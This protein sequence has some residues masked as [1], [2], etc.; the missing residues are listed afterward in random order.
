MRPYFRL[1]LRP[2][3][4]TS[5]IILAL[6]EIVFLSEQFTGL[7]DRVLKTGGS[8]LDLLRLLLWEVPGILDLALPVALLVGVQ[9]AV[10]RARTQGE[11]VVLTAAGAPVGGL[12]RGVLLVG[13]L[14]GLLSFAIAGI[15]APAASYAQRVALHALTVQHIRARISEPGESGS[16][17]RAQGVDFVA[18]GTDDA[19]PSL[20]VRR[21]P[22]AR[23][24]RFAFAGEWEV[25]GPDEDGDRGNF[26][27]GQV[28]AFGDLPRLD[29]EM[30][31]AQM[32]RMAAGSVDV[33]FD[34]DD[35]LPVLDRTPRENERPV[36]PALQALMA[37]E[38]LDEATNPE[39]IARIWARALLV[40]TAALLALMAVWGGSVRGVRAAALPLALLALVA[41]DL[42]TRAWL[43]GIAAGPSLWAASGV[44]TL[45]LLGLPLAA[46]W[47]AGEA[48]VRPGRG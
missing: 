22:D 17:F 40:P 36:V 19:S 37:G 6:V 12:V 35:I 32:N 43:V 46:L 38:V 2:I 25:T 27:L 18:T 45:V 31:E 24:W 1:T 48:L 11:L 29:G 23:P 42:V 5:L 39:R 14:G 4:A 8:G 10:G 47:R 15:I 30:T 20:M 28:T 34:M 7:M 3:L 44:V 16:T 41:C 13:L 26:R 9:S 21:P 33:G